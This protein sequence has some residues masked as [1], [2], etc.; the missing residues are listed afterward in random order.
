MRY[1]ALENGFIDVGDSVWIKER[2][3]W[4]LVWE[5]SSKV[6]CQEADFVGDLM[7]VKVVEAI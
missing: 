3:G 2:N 7:Y 5:Y 1:T 6:M 4:L